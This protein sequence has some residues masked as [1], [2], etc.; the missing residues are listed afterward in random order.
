M[1]VLHS[2]IGEVIKMDSKNK[3][4]LSKNELITALKNV[5]TKMDVVA[6]VKGSEG[7][8]HFQK[9]EST[10]EIFWKYTHDLY[11]S[12][13]FFLKQEEDLFRFSVNGKIDLKE[14]PV[15]Q[16]KIV[17]FGIRSCDVK[18]LEY[19]DL[20][21]SNTYKDNYYLE[22]RKR[23]ILVSMACVK[24]P[25]DTCFCICTNSGPFLESGFDLQIVD[26]GEQYL[27]D[28]GTK[29]GEDFLKAGKVK[30]V[31][32]GEK[33]LA[34]VEE[35]KKEAD[36]YFETATY[37]AKAIV[38]VTGNKV[39]RELWE[40]FGEACI[41]CGS[42]THLCPMCTCFDV[43]DWM[44]DGNYG[45]RTRNWDSCHYAGYTRE[46]SGHN[47]RGESEERVKRRCY[48]KLSYQYMKINN[49]LHGCVGCGRC[50]IAC[51]VS[52]DIPTIVK[53]IRREGLIKKE[54]EKV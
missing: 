6:P 53:R 45:V 42:C 28:I 46:A 12:K 9:I 34:R 16:R 44:E 38:Q 11:P 32:A 29:K 10:E 54:I 24:P 25:F 48:H 41:S 21:F 8:T 50:V 37:F 15:S 18:G 3:I 52:L 31:N 7:E 47:P 5:M 13:N 33:E 20:F 1:E 35:L 27:I 49:N 30:L 23:S 19:S 43:Y 2:K 39:K 51:P 36:V 4:I 26:L 14:F 22:K 17:I 40:D